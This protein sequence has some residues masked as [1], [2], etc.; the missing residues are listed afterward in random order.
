[1]GL[2]MKSL[3]VLS[4]SGSCDRPGSL[5]SK[6]RRVPTPRIGGLQ[7]SSL[8]LGF[9][10]SRYWLLGL[11]FIWRV[12]GCGDW[13]FEPFG[14]LWELFESSILPQVLSP[15]ESIPRAP[16]HMPQIVQLLCIVGIG[17]SGCCTLH[18][19]LAAPNKMNQSDFRVSAEVQNALPPWL[20][21][22]LPQ[23]NNRD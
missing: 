12:L 6:E 14:V 9:W 19:R 15:L 21:W 10:G 2:L 13:I 16:K 20:K 8:G 18:L 22:S 1:M 7:C 23:P 4:L 17:L 3:V 5:S 11:R